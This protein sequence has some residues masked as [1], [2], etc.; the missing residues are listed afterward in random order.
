MIRQKEFK[1]EQEF[2]IS[3]AIKYNKQQHLTDASEEAIPKF[4]MQF[5]YKSGR[6]LKKEEYPMMNLLQFLVY[7]ETILQ[8]LH[9]EILRQ[10]GGK[11]DAIIC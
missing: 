3:K 10:L 4:S 7:D 8:W 1:V 5:D 9:L 11:C 2:Q 6:E